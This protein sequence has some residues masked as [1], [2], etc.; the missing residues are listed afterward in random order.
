MKL[1]MWNVLLDGGSRI[2]IILKELKKK[3]GLKKLQPVP[4]MVY[5]AD[6]WKLQPIGLI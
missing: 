4:F 1:G 6:Q 2:S 3:L 5:V